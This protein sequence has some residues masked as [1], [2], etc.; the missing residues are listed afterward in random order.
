MMRTRTLTSLLAMGWLGLAAWAQSS[1]PLARFNG[2]IST[3]TN[4][5]PSFVR[6]SIPVNDECTGAAVQALSDGSFV[7]VNGNSEN[8]TD[9]YGFGN[10]QVWEGFSVN[11]C[12][13][14]TIGLCGTTPAF[15]NILALLMVDCDPL[16]NLAFS[17]NSNLT[18]CGDGNWTITFSG[19]AP[20]TY[21]VPVLDIPGSSGPYTLNFSAAACSATPPANDDCDGAIALTPS[22]SCTPLVVDVTGATPSSPAT[23]CDGDAS[24]DV[25]FMF[26]AVNT[27]HTVEVTPDPLYDAIFEVL[28]GDCSGLTSL[29]CQD[30]LGTGQVETLLLTG[31]SI[32]QTYYVRVYDW[33][34]GQPW[35]PLVGICILGEAPVLPPANDECGDAETVDVNAFGDC[36]S[37]EVTGTTE[38]ATAADEA[39][40][41]AG[42]GN[43]AD[44]WYG[45]NSGDNMEITVNLAATTAGAV[46]A[47]LLDACG[48]T[49]LWCDT[50]ATAPFTWTVDANTDYVVRIWTNLDVDAAG[51]FTLCLNAP[52]VIVPPPANDDCG[53]AEAIDVN[54]FG[55]CPSA[56]VT[57]TTGNATASDE[58]ACAAGTGNTADVWYGFNS[59]D[60]TEIIVNLAATTAGAVYAELLDA[61]GG[62]SLWCDTTATAPFTWA[63]DA[64]T[65]YVVRIW[66]NLDVD[67]A[68]EFT[69]CLNA[70]EVIIPPANDDCA[71]AEIATVVLPTEC[72]AIYTWGSTLN[73]SGIDAPFC[74]TGNTVDV[75]YTFNSGDNTEIGVALNATTADNVYAE[76]L[77][78]CGGMAI[79]CDQLAGS[80]FTWTVDANTDYIVRIY[81]DTDMGVG[82]EFILCLTSTSIPPANDDCANPIGL[83]VN[84]VLECPLNA[85][86]GSNATA[87]ISTDEPACDAGSTGGYQDV[88]YSFFSGDNTFIN[89]EL[90]WGTATDLWLELLDACSGTSLWCDAVTPPPY[91]WN[92]DVNTTYIIR[93]FTNTDNGNAG[94]F[95]ICLSGDFGTGV[96]VVEQPTLTAYPNPAQGDVNIV[97]D[98]SLPDATIELFDV[99][100]RVVYTQRASIQEGQPLALPLTGRVAR[101]SYTLRVLGADAMATLR[102]TME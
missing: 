24:D 62:T 88:F 75:W 5:P 69:L 89:V 65:D 47:E 33:Y 45:F 59:A 92:V 78:A 94:N 4:H 73:A 46:Y 56:E 22:N 40:C 29:A 27:E 13:D 87:V 77:D 39:A 58:A 14:V 25:W 81:T 44:V 28:S 37:A 91:V 61:C 85:V 49:S 2:P 96:N 3:F 11:E 90:D 9:E 35:V 100:G 54:A 55:D 19:L 1:N 41:T 68:G 8:A 79:W 31:L 82:G 23:T 98:R 102:V 50:T 26:T 64:N 63:V 12:M 20:G 95:S 43:T 74:A 101:G 48:G 32:G 30:D 52:E 67:A 93:V 53:D 16:T 76:L 18:D 80:D 34:A 21:F 38:A 97:L 10:P 66:T 7:T 86:A 36:P 60:N 17:G 57:G 84:E 6:G 72:S 15:V 42:T 51:A 99:T 83:A 70:P 71:D